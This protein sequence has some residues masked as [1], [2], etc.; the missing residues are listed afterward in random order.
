M[1]ARPV[2]VAARRD[3]SAALATFRALER[4]FP[5]SAAG[6]SGEADTYL[7]MAFAQ[8][9]TAQFTRRRDAEEALARY[10]RA[11]TLDPD[12]ELRFGIARALAELGRPA[13]AAGLIAALPQSAGTRAALVTYLEAAH[14]NAA[15]HGRGDSGDATRG[16]R[17]VP[18]PSRRQARPAGAEQPLSLGAGT[19]TALHI[20]P[21]C[22]R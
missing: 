7:R 11:A 13:Q 20:P 22:S 8:P 19:L 6:W 21:Y 15:A 10:R 14:R 18:E 2:P 4:S 5:R 1:A 17:C 12:P 9:R 3:P 16:H